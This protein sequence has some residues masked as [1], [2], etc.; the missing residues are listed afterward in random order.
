M[1]QAYGS[2]DGDNRGVTDARPIFCAHVMKKC[3][4]Q[5]NTRNNLASRTS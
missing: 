1:K 3:K 2:R 4:M 5:R